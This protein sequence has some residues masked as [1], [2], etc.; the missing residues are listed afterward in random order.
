MPRATRE[1]SWH[2]GAARPA[3]A[4]GHFLARL[5]YQDKV[6]FEERQRLT[7]AVP[8]ALAIGSEAS[9]VE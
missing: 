3:P 7:E 8:P 6:Q 9:T 2:A 5:L 4:P 1:S